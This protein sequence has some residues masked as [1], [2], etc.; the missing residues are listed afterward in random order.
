[1]L[2]G[3]DEHGNVNF[4]NL[5]TNSVLTFEYYSGQNYDDGNDFE[6]FIYPF[7]QIN[8]ISTIESA[9]DVSAAIQSI[10]TDISNLDNR[11]ST[12]ENNESIFVPQSRQI[13]GMNLKGDITISNLKIALG[14]NN[15]P[16]TYT[17]TSNGT[18]TSDLHVGDSIIRSCTG[19]RSHHIDNESGTYNTSIQEVWYVVSVETGIERRE[20]DYSFPHDASEYTIYCPTRDKTV[21]RLIVGSPSEITFNFT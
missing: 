9:E 3:L 11:V 16:K 1:M 2:I 4:R 17:F 5:K 12:V 14:L 6:G 8:V 19:S 7:N 15:L 21:K 20:N 13:A 18:V 10:N